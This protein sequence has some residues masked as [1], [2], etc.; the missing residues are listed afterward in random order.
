MNQKIFILTVALFCSIG[1]V[2]NPTQVSSDVLTP[3]PWKPSGRA[4]LQFSG[5][6]VLIK[7]AGHS[8]VMGSDDTLDLEASPAHIVSF[9][10]DFYMD[11]TDVTEAQYQ[12]VMDT[13]PTYFN[14]SNFYYIIEPSRPVDMVSWHD[15]VRYC[16]KLSI[17]DGLTPCYDTTTWNCT[18]TNSGYRLP[19]EAEW[20]YACRGGTTTNFYWGND[21]SAATVDLYAWFQLNY[22]N[23]VFYSASGVHPV[24]QKLPN[25]YGLYDMNGNVDQMCNDW[26]GNY[27]STTQIDPTGEPTSTTGCVIRGGDWLTPSVCLRSARRW[28]IGQP[29]DSS[30]NYIGFR[31]VRK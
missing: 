19:T 18:F 27:T 25:V 15:A 13:N 29:L 5:R 14:V 6:M 12:A 10:K 17:L 16:N 23:T 20:E 31:C 8:F 2:N 11:T 22:E 7:A 9:T 1:C 3:N 30:L 21:S 24:A 4:D 28:S 26:Y